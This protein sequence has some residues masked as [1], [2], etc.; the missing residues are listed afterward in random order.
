MK[1][2]IEDLNSFIV[3]REKKILKLPQK[4][5]KKY[6]QAE[7]KYYKKSTFNYTRKVMRRFKK[8]KTF[9]SSILMSITERI[10]N[11]SISKYNEFS[12]RYEEQMYEII[13]SVKDFYYSYFKI[14][15]LP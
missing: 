13:N 9:D 1:N 15:R 4:E 8:F 11:K 2:D 6:L 14:P 7:F 5:K 10:Y 12:W 3:K